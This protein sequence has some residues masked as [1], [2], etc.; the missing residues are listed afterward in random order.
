MRLDPDPVR[1]LRRWARPNRNW[2]AAALTVAGLC[3]VGWAGTREADP[4]RFAEEI[5]R[6]EEWDRKNSVPA[7]AVLFVGSSS[8]RFW[9]TREC[10]PQHPVI[11]RGFGGAYMSDVVHY[12]RQIVIPYKP[13]VIVLYAGD[14]DV[15]D[16]KRPEQVLSDFR[17]FVKLVRSELPKTRIVC[18]SIKPS[19]ARW[20][21]WLRMREANTLLRSAC[22][23]DQRLL[24]GDVATP[25]LD[26]DHQP[27][28][29]LYVEDRL[30]LN[31]AGYEVWSRAL[32]PL[33]ER[34]MRPGR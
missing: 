2:A 4:E 8:I 31:E 23:F 16:G 6:F 11:N 32:A 33:L 1:P 14:N 24:Y 22:E 25:M 10:F 5:R 28:A 15:A 30:H 7:D 29:D 17:D 18:L 13:K 19:P 34:A 20:D 9:P 27:K 21:H 12:A 3:L 26:Q